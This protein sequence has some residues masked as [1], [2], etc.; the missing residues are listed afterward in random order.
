MRLMENDMKEATTFYHWGNILQTLNIHNNNV[1]K[2]ISNTQS[3]L[4]VAN[5]FYKIIGMKANSKVSGVL[6]FGF[7]ISCLIEVRE[8]I[9]N[10]SIINR[11][12][13]YTEISTS[14]QNR[15]LNLLTKDFK[16]QSSIILKNN[17]INNS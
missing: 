1:S 6:L 16:T 11:K 8:N 7:N 12:H 2:I 4:G 10:T 14:Q 15:R 9:T 5:D 17:N 3:S 13:P